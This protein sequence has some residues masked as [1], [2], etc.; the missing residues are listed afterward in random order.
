MLEPG[1]HVYM[2]AP[3]FNDVQWE[4]CN[5]IEEEF[6]TWNIPLFSPRHDGGVLLPDA[7]DE[8]RK[9][10]FDM[11]VLAVDTAAW[12]LM[13]VDDFDTGTIW[14]MGYAYAKAVDILVYS[15]VQGRGLNVMLSGAASLGFINGKVDLSLTLEGLPDWDAFPRNTWGGQTQ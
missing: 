10:I 14:E 12:M 13:V 2:A 7:I 3:F 6:R 4:L 11:N 8:E 5:W 9:R 1:K 15:D